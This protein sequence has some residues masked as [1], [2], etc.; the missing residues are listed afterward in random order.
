MGERALTDAEKAGWRSYWD[1]WSACPACVAVVEGRTGR[2]WPVPATYNIV[3]IRPGARCATCSVTAPSSP[4][5]IDG[6]SSRDDLNPS[7][8]SPTD[9]GQ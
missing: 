4:A 3:G 7:T 1:G 6:E 2:A 9:Q 8:H 5:V